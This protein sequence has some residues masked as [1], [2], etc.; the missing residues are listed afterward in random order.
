[1]ELRHET[2]QRASLSPAVWRDIPLEQQ[3]LIRHKGFFFIDDFLTAPTF[4][5]ATPQAPYITVQDTGVTIKGETTMYGGVME[6]A[7]ADA[8]NDDGGIQHGMNVYGLGAIDTSHPYDVAFECRWR[9]PSTASVS[10]FIGIAEPGR[11]VAGTLADSTG[12]LVDKDMIGFHILTAAATTMNFVYRKEGETAV[13]AVA[14]VVTVAADT[15]YKLGFRYTARNKRLTAY[16]NGEEVGYVNLAAATTFPTAVLMAPLWFLK[17]HT[18][19]EKKA[20]LDWWAFSM[21]YDG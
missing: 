2:K 18:T 8:A 7:G 10:H 1:M 11:A 20:L 15:W 5:T 13:T 19:A 14:G 16:V 6:I 3:R 21:T 12:A 4:A 17:A 9:T